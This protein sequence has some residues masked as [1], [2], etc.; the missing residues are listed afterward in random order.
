MAVAHS[1]GDGEAKRAVMVVRRVAARCGAD[2]GTATVLRGETAET[3]GGNAQRGDAI[4]DGWGRRRGCAGDFADRG[5]N[6]EYRA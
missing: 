4:H 1:G 2:A 6:G 5:G 3:R